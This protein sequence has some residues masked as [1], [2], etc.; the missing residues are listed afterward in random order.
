[1]LFVPGDSECKF[2]K[3]REAGADVLIP[4]LDDAVAPSQKDIARATVARLLDD[5]ALRAWRFFVRPNPF[6][7]GLTLADLAAVVRPGPEGATAARL[8]RH[9][10]SSLARQ[11]AAARPFPP[12]SMELTL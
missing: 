1:M 3:G 10:R 9:I 4:D 11:G 7:T 5:P 2:A 6:D 8:A 12:E